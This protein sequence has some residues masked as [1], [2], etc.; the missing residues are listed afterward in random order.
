MCFARRT[1]SP[2]IAL[3]GLFED[4]EGNIWVSTYDGGLDR[5]RDFAVPDF[6]QR[7]GLSD[8]TVESGLGGQGW[9]HLVR[10]DRWFE[11]LE[12]WPAYHLSQAKQRFA[13]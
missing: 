7:Q 10:N 4:R 2:A 11:P 8:A 12:G 13:G 3:R 6:R 5:F 9:K 1:A